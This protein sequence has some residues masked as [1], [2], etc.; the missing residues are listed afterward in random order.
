M[1]AL[2]SEA[3]GFFR[4]DIDGQFC[5]TTVQKWTVLNLQ[6]SVENGFGSTDDRR[7]G[8]KKS[9]AVTAQSTEIRR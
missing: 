1:Q 9:T 4:T 2:L 8:K 7:R 3:I 6:M 5:G